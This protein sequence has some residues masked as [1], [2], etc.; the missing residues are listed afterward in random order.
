MS[1]TTKLIKLSKWLN[2]N[3]FAREAMQINKFAERVECYTDPE[4]EEGFCRDSESGNWVSTG[5]A[6]G[7]PS[8]APDQRY[9]V[10]WTQIA[11]EQGYNSVEAYVKSIYEEVWTAAGDLTIDELKSLGLHVPTANLEM[12]GAQK[13]QVLAAVPELQQVPD[14]EVI[15]RFLA[16]VVRET[17]G[18]IEGS[19]AVEYSEAVLDK[20][21][22]T[23][24]HIAFILAHELAHGILQH[25]KSLAQSSISAKNKL[26]ETPELT[27]EGG[28]G[29]PYVIDLREAFGEVDMTLQNQEDELSADTLG[30]YIA[31]NAGFDQGAGGEVIQRLRVDDTGEDK[32]AIVP[33]RGHAHQSPY[34]EEFGVDSTQTHPSYAAR[35]QNLQEEQ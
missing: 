26:L 3:G 17:G 4:T 5:Y 24:D 19:L 14:E 28:D 12:F 16:S 20:K 21:C 8:L 29:E 15:A 9:C 2:Q 6:Q 32:D 22:T 25:A 27:I 23:E 11:A 7:M 33:P 30:S 13:E 10:D 18:M 34:Q 35:W 31:T 1:A